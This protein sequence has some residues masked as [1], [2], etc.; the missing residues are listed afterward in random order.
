V[1]AQSVTEAEAKVIKDFVTAGVTL[2]YKV[3]GA[4]ESKIIR[5]I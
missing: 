4:R 1:D 2:D 3:N 5:V